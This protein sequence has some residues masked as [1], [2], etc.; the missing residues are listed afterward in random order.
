MD[1]KHPVILMTPVR[2]RCA[3]H[4]ELEELQLTKDF[5]EVLSAAGAIPL[6]CA[7]SGI[8]S[9]LAALSDALLLTGGHDLSP[10]LYGEDTDE[11][12]GAVD[13]WRDCLEKELMDE[14]IRAGKPIFGV[15]R[16]HQFINV[17]FGGTLYQDLENAGICHPPKPHEVGALPGSDLSA[18]FG[19]SFRVN[20]FHHQA[21]KRLG[22]GLK[23]T[24]FSGE[25][26][27]AMVHQSLPV[28]SVQ[29]HPERMTGSELNDPSLPDMF[30]LFA[31]WVRMIDL[32]SR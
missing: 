29:W 14:F 6:I 25:I 24:A 32:Q 1:N 15:C 12:C 18:L 28:R 27:E 20:S 10:A 17:Y 19:E 30:P 26:V 8:A 11:L 21:V 22:E 5:G 9:Q 13:A 31:S 16:G 23:A 3:P 2:G 7:C 4:P